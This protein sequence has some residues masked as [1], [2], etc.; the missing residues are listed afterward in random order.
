VLL[1]IDTSAGTSV[2]VVDRDAGVLAELIETDTRRH[3]EVIGSL[4]QGALDE[5]GIAVTALS[6]VAVGMGPGPFTGLR[7]GIAAARA[8]ALGIGRP[9]VPVVSHDAVAF[10][11][12]APVLVV[13]DAR[14]REVYWSAYSG[15]GAEGLP[16]RLLGPGLSAPD[17]LGVNVPGIA[18]YRRVDAEVVSAGSLG[19]V[20][21]LLYL[22]N[23][24][25]ASSE[26]LYLRSPD[27]TMSSG[28]KRV[29]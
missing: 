9:V 11:Q 2:A 27:V 3:A 18:S 28:P 17:D 13:T 10:G 23:R 21:E 20:A 6:G 24:P 19:L 14:R 29:S 22:H 26:A 7:V 25:F 1:A 8:F 5:A 16:V 12:I 4:I 15:T